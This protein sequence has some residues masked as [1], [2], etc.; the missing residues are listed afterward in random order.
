MY[1]S[2]CN[3]LIPDLVQYLSDFGQR[4]GIATFVMFTFVSMSTSNA[5]IIILHFS[6]TDI[7]CRKRTYF[8]ISLKQCE[9]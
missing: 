1:A 7:V 5:A 2:F 8:I 6:S 9:Q 4:T 3:K